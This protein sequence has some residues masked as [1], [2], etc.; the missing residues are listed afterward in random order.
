M[1][2]VFNI[3]LVL[4]LLGWAIVLGGTLTQ[5]KSPRLATGV[6]HGILTALVTG[7]IMIGLHDSAFPDEPKLNMV[8]FGIK[9]VVAAVVCA[10]V[11]FGTRRPEKVTTKFLGSIAG[12]TV[13]NVALAVL[14]S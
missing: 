8:K 1:S 5:L 10:L 3:V 7:I 4:H 6:L 11:I 14:W 2:T 13:A 12:L 9:L